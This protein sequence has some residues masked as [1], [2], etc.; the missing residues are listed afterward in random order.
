MVDR[1]ESGIGESITQWLSLCR[2]GSDVAVDRVTTLVYQDLRR[3]ASYYLSGAGKVRTL[4]PT[5][6]KHE[7]YLRVGEI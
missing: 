7:A 2:D 6:L 5:A 3:L 4:Q 1:P